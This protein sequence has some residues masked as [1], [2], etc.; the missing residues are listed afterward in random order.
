[1]SLSSIHDQRVIG[2]S[3]SP[4]RWRTI[5]KARHPPSGAFYLCRG[6]NSQ[7]KRTSDLSQ[8][9][10]PPGQ[11]HLSAGRVEVGPCECISEQGRSRSSSGLQMAAPCATAMLGVRAYS[12]RQASSPETAAQT[13][14][15]AS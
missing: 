11:V 14:K 6:V 5:R 8:A 2:T 13:A 3:D 7:P 4:T 12:H 10:D 15:A 1:M 9:E